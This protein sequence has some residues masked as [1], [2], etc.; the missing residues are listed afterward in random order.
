MV[1]G[2]IVAG[3]ALVG[4]ILAKDW[5]TNKLLLWAGGM[6]DEAIGASS[7]DQVMEALRLSGSY[8]YSVFWNGVN[9]ALGIVEPFGYALITTYFL[10]HLFDAA[11]KDQVTVDSV[12]KVMIQLVLAVALV[13][14]LDAIVNA[15]LSISE[16]VLEGVNTAVTA[17]Y[18]NAL[19]Q[20]GGT[21]MTGYEIVDIWYASGTDMS[22]TIWIQCLLLWLAHKISIIAVCFA[23][24]SRLIEIGWRTVLAPI[25]IANCFE[26]G[27]NSKGIQYLKTL[28]VTCLSGTAIYLVVALGFGLCQV[29]VRSFSGPD[30]G[31]FWMAMGAMLATAGASIGVSNKIRDLA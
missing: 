27:A 4:G 16:S 9:Q 3:A 10:M 12:I 22:G 8:D 31:N 15:F 14:N 13:S 23:V 28:F 11:A 20:V 25:G 2:L 21:P 17:A 1:A 18:T 30:F 29:Y 5:L 6:L 19:S 24:F 26:G 7:L